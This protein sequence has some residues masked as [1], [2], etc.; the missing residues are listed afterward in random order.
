MRMLE[1]R[2]DYTT[3]GFSSASS[4]AHPCHRL[5][6]ELREDLLKSWRTARLGLLDDARHPLLERRPALM[7]ERPQEDVLL[8][9]GEREGLGLVRHV[10]VLGNLGQLRRDHLV[11]VVERDAGADDIEERKT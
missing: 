7:E 4:S 3:S 10:V 5:S 11:G 8:L 1:T 9:E 6:R 2:G